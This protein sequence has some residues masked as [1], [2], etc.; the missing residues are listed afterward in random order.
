MYMYVSVY[1]NEF[2][3]VSTSCSVYD[4][5]IFQCFTIHELVQI[6]FAFPIT[7]RRIQFPF[8]LTWSNLLTIWN[9]SIKLL[10]TR[11]LI[12]K[13]S[14]KCY[15]LTRVFKIRWFQNTCINLWKLVTNGN[16]KGIGVWVIFEYIVSFLQILSNFLHTFL[17][18]HSCN[19]NHILGWDIPKYFWLRAN[20]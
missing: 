16:S 15:G 20:L 5:P 12:P 7:W 13:L 17:R 6:R 19:L 18:P 4:K 14:S 10:R 11:K 8:P 2:S 1:L 3:I 9:M